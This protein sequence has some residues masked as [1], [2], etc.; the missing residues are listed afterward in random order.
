MSDQGELGEVEAELAPG[1]RP[2]DRLVQQTSGGR[3]Q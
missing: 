1:V 2:D 3:V